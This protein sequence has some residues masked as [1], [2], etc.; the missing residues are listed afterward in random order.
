MSG[1][2]LEAKIIILVR[3][4]EKKIKPYNCGEASIDEQVSK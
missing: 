3:G 1:D 4:N 2:W